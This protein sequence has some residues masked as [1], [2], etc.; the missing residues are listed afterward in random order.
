MSASYLNSFVRPNELFGDYP[1][2]LLHPGSLKAFL[3]GEDT[4]AAPQAIARELTNAERAKWVGVERRS[5]WLE[6]G[7][8]TLAV[9][10]SRPLSPNVGAAVYLFGYRRD[11]PFAQMPKLVVTLKVLTH[12]VRDGSRPLPKS[13]VDVARE[14]NGFVIRAPLDLLGN[15]ELLMGSARTYAGKVPLDW[16]AWRVLRVPS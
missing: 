1:D 16:I 15:P 12:N 6:Q 13:A 5:V 14:P 10:F 4:W 8:F 2:A 11:R 7:C 3:H 9:Q